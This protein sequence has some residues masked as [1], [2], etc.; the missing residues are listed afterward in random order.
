MQTGA[1]SLVPSSTNGVAQNG[2]ST[3]VFGVSCR[4]SLILSYG[5]VSY[6]WT[7]TDSG[8]IAA[9]GN[10]VTDNTET[11]NTMLLLPARI[12]TP[13]NRS[14][15]SAS[16][17]SEVPGTTVWKRDMSQYG[18]AARC[19]GFNGKMVAVSNGRSPSPPN[20]CGPDSAWYSALVPNLDFKGCCNTHD[21]CY[22]DCTQWFEKCNTDFLSCMINTCNNKYDHWYSWW[23]LPSCYA[24]ADLYFVAVSTDTAQ[25]HFQSG[26]N[27][28]CAC[29]CA[30]ADSAICAPETKT[31]QRVRGIGNNDS[32]NCGGCGRDCGPRAHCSDGQCLCNP[33]PPTPDQCGNMCLDFLTHPRHCGRCNNVCPKG[34]CYQGACFTPPENADKCYP[35]DAV[36]NGDFSAGLTG[37]SVSSASGARINYNIGAG[38]NGNG[39][40]LAT[41]PTQPTKFTDSRWDTIGV[42]TTL[43]LC[44]GVQYKLDFQTYTN[45][46]M[47]WASVIVGGHT[48]SEQPT[49]VGPLNA[50]AAQGPYTLPIF[51]KGDAGTSQGDGFF[52]N[53]PLYIGFF[54]NRDT[55]YSTRLADVA[56]YS[57]GE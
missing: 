16:K 55:D 3:T 43:R 36:T 5:S 12:R 8:T 21:V 40:S 47:M 27:D 32:K 35:V 1:I 33:A 28:V 9:P 42:S 11:L 17:R 24:A 49:S 15:P 25:E 22:D 7:T 2:K 26:S 46:P 39:N 38:V 56:V 34:Y 31:C 51:K 4:G 37:W 41:F 30:D 48:I 29:R 57:T 23:L 20:G 54:G 6:V 52:L 53:V 13:L 50:W 44:A 19:P 18:A 10:P 14:S 45:D